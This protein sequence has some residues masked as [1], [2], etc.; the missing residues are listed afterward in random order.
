MRKRFSIKLSILLSILLVLALTTCQCWG[1][2]AISANPPR[3]YYT[4][5][6]GSMGSQKV[7]LSNPGDKPLEIGVSLG[8]WNYDSLGNNK[9]YEQGTLKTSCAN[10]LQIFPGSYFTLAPKA[11][12]ELTV[13]VTMPKDADT[14][15][16]VHTAMLY[17]TQLNPENSANKKGAT[18]KISLRM[19]IKVY[20]NFALDNSKE[21]EVENLFD[22]TKIG[23]DKKPV[24]YLCLNFKN[25]GGLWLEGSIKWQILNE[26]TGKEVKIQPTNFY[27]LPGDNRYEYI[28]L[29]ADLEKGRYSATA[30]ITYGNK[31]EVKIAQLEFAN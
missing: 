14:S 24:R 18:I 21:I 28:P 26:S 16:P 5:M 13:N 15:L 23:L 29:P 2:G 12:Q 10:W 11:S 20:V 8:D 1:Q 19:A 22:I 27:S 31:D 9:L 3:L 17:F 6:P 30:L 7:Q 25:T 4:L